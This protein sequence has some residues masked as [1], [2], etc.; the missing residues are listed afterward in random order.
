MALKPIVFLHGFLGQPSDWAPVI[1]CLPPHLSIKIELPGHGTTAFTKNFTLNLSFPKFHLVGYSMGGRLALQ[2]ARKFPEKIASLTILS[3]HPGLHTCDE[4]KSRLEIDKKWA[5]KLL[6]LPID[7]FLAQWYD[8][9]LFQSFKPDFSMRRNHNP[10]ALAAALLHYS[11]G[12]QDFYQPKEALYLVGEKDEK[13]RSIYKSATIIP[14]AGHV[15]HL[16][17]PKAVA[18]VI[19]QRI[20]S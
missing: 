11:L 6:K 19:E 12:A 13:Y 9:P 7:E 14:N 2:Y 5:T 18:E 4:K 20:F 16:E 1:S 17:N 15:V 10:K 3:A 8:Q